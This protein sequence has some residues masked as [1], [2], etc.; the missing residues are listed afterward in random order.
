MLETEF[1]EVPETAEQMAV[2]W[3][4]RD[5]EYAKQRKPL[6]PDLINAIIAGRQR[7]AGRL[8]MADRARMFTRATTWA[9]PVNPEFGG[10]KDWL[11]E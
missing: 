6:A 2:R 8:P 11:D 1:P 9:P 4:Q 3:A 5:A 7:E 10:L